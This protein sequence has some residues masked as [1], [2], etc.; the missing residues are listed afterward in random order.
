[1]TMPT[2]H[3]TK[4]DRIVAEARRNA[5]Q[6]EMLASALR[7]HALTV[8]PSQTNFLLTQFAAPGDNTRVAT[9]EAALCELGIV[10]RPMTGY[11]LGHW[12]MPR[13][14]QRLYVVV[15]FALQVLLSRW[16][17]AKFRFGL[18][19]WLWRWVTYGRRPPLRIAA[20]A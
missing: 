1:M 7:S 11:G 5:E 6:R 8:F 3:D 15:V 16:W 18:L 14:Q 17:L 12:G 19:E 20:T 10:L 4:L 2:P 9:I 13:A